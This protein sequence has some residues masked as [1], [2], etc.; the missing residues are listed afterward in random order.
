MQSIQHPPLRDCGGASG[1]FAELAIV[2]LGPPE[3]LLGESVA[4]IKIVRRVAARRRRIELGF[5]RH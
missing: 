2:K 1:L 5:T 4:Q 3:E